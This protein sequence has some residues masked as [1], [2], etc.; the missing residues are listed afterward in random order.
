MGGKMVRVIRNKDIPLLE[1]VLCT[2]QNMRALQERRQWQEEQLT[3]ITQ[4]LR[5]T[6]KLILKPSCM[7]MLLGSKEQKIF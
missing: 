3:N 7:N 4:H 1:S 5:P 6:S 2:M